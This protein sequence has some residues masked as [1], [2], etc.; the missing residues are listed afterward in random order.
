[1]EK[2]GCHSA[3]LIIKGRSISQVFARGW[4]R[5]RNNSVVVKPCKRTLYLPRQRKYGKGAVLDICHRKFCMG[6]IRG[7]GQVFS[8]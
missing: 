8:F 1:M 3:S 4:G 7:I 5:A 2:G 6:G